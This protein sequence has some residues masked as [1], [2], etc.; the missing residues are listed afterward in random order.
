VVE[1]IEKDSRR[2]IILGIL[3][4]SLFIISIDNM[5]LNLA[6]PSISED[7]GASA[8]QL[9]WI[10]D[11]YVLVFAALLL[12][13]GA[14]GDRYG[15]KRILQ[16]GAVLFGIGSLAAALSASTEM[17]I[18]C[19][20]FLGIG[21]AMIMPSTLSILT[22]TFR[23]PKE[24]AKAIAMWSAVFLLGAAAGPVIG[25]YLLQYFSWSA[26]FYINL[27]VV[28]VAL[29][30]GYI[31]I[32]ESKGEGAPK[33]DFAGVILS[34]GGLF[35]LVYGIIE[36]GQKG[37]TDGTVLAC[38]GISV[39]VLGAFAW[40]ENRCQT[41]MLPFKFFRNMSFTGA[42]LALVLSAFAMMGSMFFMSQ[43]LQSVQG[44]SPVASALRMLPMAGTAFVATL[45]SARIAEWMGNKLVVSLGILIAGGGLLYFSLVLTPDTAYGVLVGGIVIL[46]VGM[47]L[48]MSPST[49]A[50][51]GSLPVSRA[52]IGSAMNDTTRQ[53]GGALG[54]AVLG[55]L[56]NAT[57]LDKIEGL[58][59]VASLPAEAAEAVRSSIQGA[60]IV[61]GQLPS[62]ASQAVVDGTNAAFTAGMNDAMFI[63]AII[64]GICALITFILLPQRVQVLP[65]H[66]DSSPA[67]G[68]SPNEAVEKMET[69]L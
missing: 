8:S 51:Q 32:R 43:Y 34:A 22:D 29:I 7:L 26:V 67:T 68:F 48:T 35:A 63:G 30:G 41:P 66:A 46:A 58:D 39:L 20:A 17:L 60:H 1:Q 69:Q 16:I 53:V 56:M 12:T 11:A 10:T 45:I 37:W 13:M 4:I 47:G 55:A 38:L 9:Q 36:A 5:V 14:I 18:A 50:I 15:R 2:W 49:N 28:I 33:P 54:V 44:Y 21:G 40:W 31:F 64:M 6:L 27:P 3:C 19:R 59:I 42:S 65:E 61:A 23:D 24:R 52:G 57:Y 62:D 25:G